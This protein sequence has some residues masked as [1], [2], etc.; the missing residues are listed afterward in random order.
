M[1]NNFGKENWAL[2][3]HIENMHTDQPSNS[4]IRHSPIDIKYLYKNAQI[5][6]V[7]IDKFLSGKLYNNCQK[8]VTVQASIT[9]E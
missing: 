8:Q 5:S 9:A 7:I 6:T 1:V 4:T 2:S 3:S